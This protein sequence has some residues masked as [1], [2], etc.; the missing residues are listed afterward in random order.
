[1]QCWTR[2]A[3]PAVTPRLRGGGPNRARRASDR[4]ATPPPRGDRPVVPPGPRGASTVA[5]SS[6]ISRSLKKTAMPAKSLSLLTRPLSHVP[7]DKAS[8]AAWGVSPGTGSGP[9]RTQSSEKASSAHS[10]IGQSPRSCCR[11]ANSP[12][13][14]ATS[15]L[16]AGTSLSAKERT[17]LP[18]RSSLASTP[19]SCAPELRRRSSR[20]SMDCARVSPPGAPQ[21]AAR[22]N[23][24]ARRCLRDS[25]TSSASQKTSAGSGAR[26]TRLR[27]SRASRSFSVPRGS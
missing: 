24:S 9:H 18:I 15:F 13:S 21:A 1:M 27:G 22:A 10:G 26:K 12:R 7:A 20:R 2:G 4:A 23:T 19:G 16:K 8:A 14:S 17:S 6:S 25:P 11:F 5:W 3:A